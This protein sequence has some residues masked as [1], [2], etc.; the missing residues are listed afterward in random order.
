MKSFLP[1]VLLVLGIGVAASFGAR[2]GPAHT[3]WRQAMALHAT[4]AS[5]QAMPT[6]SDDPEE[7]KKLV[8]AREQA[9][10]ALVESGAIA[11]AFELPAKVEAAKAA[12]PD[13][14]DPNTRL[15]EWAATGGPGFG[16]GV[17]L[18]GVGAF[19]ARRQQAHEAASGGG[20]GDLDFVGT[21]TRLSKEISALADQAS[22][23]PMDDDAPLLRAAIEKLHNDDISPLV[24][25]RG[26]F[27][28]KHGIGVFAEYFGPFSG[29]ERNLARAWSALTDGHSVVAAEALR[30][31]AASFERAAAAWP[32]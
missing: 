6:A 7:A 29:G 30:N 1:L 10:A 5:V 26:A 18:I 32:K 24:E 17:L 31:S 22:R 4:L 23:I 27:I 12:I 8:E 25:G 14:P 19:L 21:V 16:L 20:Q 15:S 28:A 2:N 11:S 3:E 13:V 9:I